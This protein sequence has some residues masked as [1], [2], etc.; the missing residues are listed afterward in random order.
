MLYTIG[1]R[2]SY[3][4]YFAEQ[5]QP[6]KLGRG[7][8]PHRPGEHYTGGIVFETIE[9]ARASC[10]DGF[11]PYGLVTTIENTYLI[12]ANRHLIETSPLAR[13]L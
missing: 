2:E 10:P 5:E 12:G 4:R 13:L 3:E 9:E 6:M 11:T 8:D 7:P 1:H